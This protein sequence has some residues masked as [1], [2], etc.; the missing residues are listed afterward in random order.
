VPGLALIDRP[1]APQT[2]IVVLRPVPPPETGP[3]RVGRRCVNTI[4]GGTFTSRLMRNLR[5]VH[6]YT[7]HAGSVLNQRGDQHELIAYTAVQADATAAALTELKREFGRLAGGDIT[8]AELDK[9]VS[10]VRYELV[11][12]GES[13]ASLVSTLADLASDGRPLDSVASDLGSLDGMDLELVN[14]VAETGLFD[15]GRLRIVLVGD[16]VEVT[17]QLAEAGFPSPLRVNV[18]GEPVGN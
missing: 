13:A 1:Q 11:E 8:A 5:E 17:R 3:E 6:G 7:Y 14:A 16:A 12:T 9:A 10:T 18:E 4:F 15:W 2:T